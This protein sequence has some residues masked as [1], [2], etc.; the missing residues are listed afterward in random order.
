MKELYEMDS[1]QGRTSHPMPDAPRLGF[2]C[3]FIPDDADAETARHMNAIAVT[4][5]LGRL[6]PNQ[7]FDKLASVVTHKLEVVRRQIEYVAARP[8]IERV[9]RLSSQVLPGFTHPTCKEYYNDLDLRQSIESSLATAGEIARR[10]GVR[11]SMHPGQFCI[12]ASLSEAASTNGIDEF[13]HPAEVMALLGYGRGWYPDGAHINIHA[14]AKGIGTEG[15]RAGLARLSETAPN[16]ITVEKRRSELRP[17]RP[18]PPGRRP[19][20][21]PRSASSL[22]CEPGRVHRAG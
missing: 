6:D 13:E 17:R 20:V 2:C 19:P 10:N 8:W 4:A 3:K 11:L 12:I 9:H 5:Y 7:A 22:G 18:A 1:F 14:G 21:R 15:F 16:L